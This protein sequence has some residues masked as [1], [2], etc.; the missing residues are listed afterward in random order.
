MEGVRRAAVS[1]VGADSIDEVVGAM[2]GDFLIKLGTSQT[3]RIRR[4]NERN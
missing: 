3:R 2:P 1:A 4:T